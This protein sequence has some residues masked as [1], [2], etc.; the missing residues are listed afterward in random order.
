MEMEEGRGGGRGL[1]LSEEGDK[2][3]A[4]LDVAGDWLWVWTRGTHWLWSR[5][6]SRAGSGKHR[7][8]WYCVRTWWVLGLT[9][10]KNEAA[11][12]HVYL[13]VW[14]LGT[15]LRCLQ[16]SWTTIWNLQVQDDQMI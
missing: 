13:P 14:V 11:D 4:G 12:P 9:D 6:G 2:M 16:P 15:S 3:E 1:G 10:F 8:T 5:P 7:M